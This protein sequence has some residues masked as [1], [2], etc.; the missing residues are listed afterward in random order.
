VFYLIFW[1]SRAGEV[2]DGNRKMQEL[3]A[4][5]FALRKEKRRGLRILR[6]AGAAQARRPLAA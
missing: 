2:R 3:P 5:R 6:A 1:A 4:A